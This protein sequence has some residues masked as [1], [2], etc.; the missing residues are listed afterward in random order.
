MLVQLVLL[1]SSFEITLELVLTE[2]L[3]DTLELVLTKIIRML[4]MRPRIIFDRSIIDTSQRC[5]TLRSGLVN[6]KANST[7]F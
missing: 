1:L 7:L 4:G 5:D 3:F 2:L 6:L